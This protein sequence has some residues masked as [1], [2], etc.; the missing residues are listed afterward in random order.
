[1]IKTAVFLIAGL[2]AGLAIA[3]W[4]PGAAELDG[5]ALTRAREPLLASRVAALESAIRDE[6]SQRTELETQ[7]AELRTELATL[8]VPEAP[9]ITA[10]TAVLE[11]GDNTVGETSGRESPAERLIQ[12]RRGRFGDGDEQRVEQLVAAGFSADRAMWINQRT[13]ELRMESLQAQYDAAREGESFSLRSALSGGEALRAELGDP[14]YERYLEATGRPTSVGVRS[15]LT[16]SPAEQAGL[17]PGDQV[18][19][20]SG[21]RVFDMSE[22]NSLILGGQPGETVAID[23]LRDGQQIQLYVPRGPI[24]IT[25]GGRFGGRP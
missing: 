19:A 8:G 21:Q 22:I 17:L 18:V 10:E 3:T 9:Q 6:A 13:A 14:D 2:V 12:G 24:G 11:R 16:S 15:V 20:Y 4:W 7:L 5:P 1:M 25:G 23:V